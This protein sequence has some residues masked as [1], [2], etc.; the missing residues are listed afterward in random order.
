MAQHDSIRR[1]QMPQRSSPASRYRRPAA[2]PVP[3]SARMPWT[4][5]KSSSLTSA[6]CE[7]LV[8]MTHPPGWA[9]RWTWRWPSPVLAGSISSWLVGWRFQTWRPV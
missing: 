5:M 6:G 8:E 4:A 2:V 3:R 7:G 9:Q 1:P